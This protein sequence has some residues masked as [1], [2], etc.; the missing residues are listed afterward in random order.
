MEKGIRERRKRESERTQRRSNCRRE[1]EK[2]ASQKRKRNNGAKD[3][4]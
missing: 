1:R 2:K 3:I 4:K